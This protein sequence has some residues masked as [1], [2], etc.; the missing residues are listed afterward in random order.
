LVQ[1]LAVSEARAEIIR[2]GDYCTM[3]GLR[4]ES[5][6]VRCGPPAAVTNVENLHGTV[7]D[8]KENA[9]HMWFVSVEQM[10]YFKGKRF[11]L[12]SQRANVP[13]ISPAMRSRL[14]MR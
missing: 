14:P 4:T 7:I 10:T 12:G 6:S 9:V 1:Q 13:E 8:H 11:A 2:G 5:K 3:A